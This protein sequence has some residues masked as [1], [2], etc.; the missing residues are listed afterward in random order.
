LVI[1][2][3][4]SLHVVGFFTKNFR[5]F[6]CP[7]HKVLERVRQRYQFV[8]VGYVL[9]PEHFHLLISEPQKASSSVVIQVS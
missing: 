2:T 9:M 1:A 5:W 8:V 4:G 3:A 6:L 7:R